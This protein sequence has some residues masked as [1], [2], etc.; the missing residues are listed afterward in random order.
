MFLFMFLIKTI[1]GVVIFAVGI[2]LALQEST[3]YH[4][5]LL[6][7]LL[8]GVGAVIT[9]NGLILVFRKIRSFF[10]RSI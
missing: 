10:A 9:V 7:N 5:G 1:I 3:Q 6:P 2:Y 8:C 4:Y